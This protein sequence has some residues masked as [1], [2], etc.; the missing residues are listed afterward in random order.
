M[1]FLTLCQRTA[2]KCGISGTIAATTGQ[3]GEAGRVVNWVNEAW[4]EIQEH[5]R[6]N[7]KLATFSFQTVAAQ[8]AYTPAQ[9]GVSNLSSWELDTF[10]SYLTATGV[11]AELFLEFVDYKTFRDIYQFSVV[12]NAQPSKFAIRPEDQAILLAQIPDG[13]YTV[14]GKYWM[15]GS[16]MT[17]TTD[18]PTGLPTDYH[19]L[20]VYGAMMKYAQYEE[21]GAVYNGAK[22]DYDRLIGQM[23]LKWLPEMDCGEPLA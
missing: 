9:A 3:S 8:Q 19:W 21:A 13:I 11:A 18:L 16:E 1:N 17:D 4:R 5:R 20:I 10:R 15:A 12:A 23:E 6:W 22:V 14:N 2:S 7:W